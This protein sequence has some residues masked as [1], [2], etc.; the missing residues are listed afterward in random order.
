MNFDPPVIREGVE[1]PEVDVTRKGRKPSKWGF[2]SSMKVGQS[3]HW[4]F[5]DDKA[6]DHFRGLLSSAA[7]RY[8]KLH[9]ITLKVRT[10]PVTGEI[11]VWREE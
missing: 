10:D 9:N 2:M 11:G 4:T 6:L 7:S 5:E 1:I 8:S 3:A